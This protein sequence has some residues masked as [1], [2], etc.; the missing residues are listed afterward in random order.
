VDAQCDHVLWASTGETHPAHTWFF[1]DYEV[2]VP[3]A[4][5]AVTD[6]FEAM[7]TWLPTE[8]I[9]VSAKWNVL[10]AGL[11]RTAL[12]FAY[13]F[14]TSSPD[15]EAGVPAPKPIWRLGVAQQLCFSSVCWSSVSVNAFANW[16]VR[17]TYPSSDPRVIVLVGGVFALGRTVKLLLEPQLV[18]NWESYLGPSNESFDATLGL[19][20]GVRISG[21]HV[22]VDI[23]LVP[24][25]T[26]EYWG[27]APWIAFTY[28]TSGERPSK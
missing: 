28:R 6:R 5:Y 20:V 13:D 18:W 14:P 19:G 1:T 4:G 7:L 15:P 11:L 26:V 25:D 2:L 27:P 8:W 21:P 23:G 16:D 24:V 17:G 3:H 10:R 12:N 22:G 9:D